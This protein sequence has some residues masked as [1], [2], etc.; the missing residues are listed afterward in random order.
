MPPKKAQTARAT[1]SGGPPDPAEQPSAKKQKQG[2]K[3]NAVRTEADRDADLARMSKELADLEASLAA[4]TSPGENGLTEAETVLGLVALRKIKESLGDL[5]VSNIGNV[6]AIGLMQTKALIDNPALLR[7]P[8]LD[9]PPRP[10]PAES[11]APRESPSEDCTLLSRPP[12]EL[13]LV[14]IIQY[15]VVKFLTDFKPAPP[16]TLSPTQTLTLTGM[17]LDASR[18]SLARSFFD[19]VSILKLVA[20]S[21]SDLFDSSSAKDKAARFMAELIQ[22]VSNSLNASLASLAC[23]HALLETCAPE[24][25]LQ[26]RTTPVAVLD[27]LAVV[28][29]SLNACITSFASSHRKDAM[30]VARTQHALDALKLAQTQQ[31]PPAATQYGASSYSPFALA[32]SRPPPPPPVTP[33]AGTRPG[34]LHGQG[35][36]AC[37][38][39]V[40]NNFACALCGKGST[41]GSV[42]H[43]ASTCPANDAEIN[44]WV[45]N[46]VP[47]V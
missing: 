9:P 12:H 38:F 34:V 31:S 42:G 46:A 33:S 47:V 25:F 19:F 15:L 1:R 43:R 11:P 6:L 20:S 24:V 35:N 41:P 32:P 3:Q 44:N 45:V 39:A 5:S 40:G 30:R 18:L 21:S 26:V 36:R 7:P 28:D 37:R 23:N 29:D 22:K 10:A 8:G 13:L 27:L 14:A 16:K 4:K 2:Q 17:T